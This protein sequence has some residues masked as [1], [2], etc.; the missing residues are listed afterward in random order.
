[1]HLAYN[2]RVTCSNIP[3]TLRFRLQMP[4]SSCCRNMVFHQME[5]FDEEDEEIKE[6]M[7]RISEKKSPY[8]I[9]VIRSLITYQI[10]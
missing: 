9:A 10:S 8:A 5:I 6:L 7:R 3:A 1:L 2:A 4:C